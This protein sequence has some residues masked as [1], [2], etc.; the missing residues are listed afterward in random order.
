MNYMKKAKKAFSLVELLVVVAILT[1]M[2]S[3]SGPAL[4][5]LLSASSINQSVE[6][7]GQTMALARTYAMANHTYVRLLF[8]QL[9]AGA[10]A[11][12]GPMLLVLA[13]Y[14]ASGGI[15]NG[16]DSPQSMGDASL[17]PALDRPLLLPNLVTNDALNCASP[18]TSGDA[19][20]S[21]SDIVPA[22]QSFTRRVAARSV[23]FTSCLQV[24]PAGETQV[25]KGTP[26]RYIKIA[27]DA[28]APRSGR[29][30]CIL[31]VDGI[32]G[33]INILRKENG[34]Q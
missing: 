33:R 6:D 17:W 23:A 3:L 15:D 25:I 16:D 21:Q 2:A 14:P 30:P 22:G 7:L 34:I 5:A 4:S 27:L 18:D 13:V 26:A 10:A 8:G 1:L 29:N 12:G 19:L 32:N 20:P 31:R 28:P 11:S 24:D 9:S